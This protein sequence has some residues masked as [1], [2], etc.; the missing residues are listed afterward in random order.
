LCGTDV[1]LDNQ[2][3]EDQGYGAIDEISGTS[4]FNEPADPQKYSWTAQSGST[5]YEIARS[6]SLDFTLA[7]STTTTTDTFWIDT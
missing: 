1:G 2:F 7:C 5:L 6:S 4:G 3:P